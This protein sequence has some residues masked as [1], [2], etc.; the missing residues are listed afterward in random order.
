[1]L[2]K[3]VLQQEG[4]QVSACGRLTEALDLVR[5]RKPALVVV[6]TR[7][8]P[9]SSATWPVRLRS[10]NP[11]LTI[12]TIMDHLPGGGDLTAAYDEY[13][14]RPVELNAIEAKVRDLLQQESGS[15]TGE[16]AEPP[17]E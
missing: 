17:I 14:T 7:S 2:L 9:R 15:G 12:L 4:H 13:L 1:M 5:S 16:S 3:R 10:E 6:N 11:R 8:D